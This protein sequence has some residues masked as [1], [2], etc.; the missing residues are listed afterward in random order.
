MEKMLLPKQ[1]DEELHCMY[2]TAHLQAVMTLTKY[3][4]LKIVWLD[5]V[6][7]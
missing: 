1:A 2:L 3:Y 7:R 4:Y 5:D 6:A